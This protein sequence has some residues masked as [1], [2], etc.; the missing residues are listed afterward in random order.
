MTKVGP[1]NARLRLSPLGEA[2]R[3]A[4]LKAHPV[5]TGHSRMPALQTQHIHIPEKYIFWGGGGKTRVKLMTVLKRNH[6]SVT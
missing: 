4:A 1:I 6:S 3:V 2:G 5:P